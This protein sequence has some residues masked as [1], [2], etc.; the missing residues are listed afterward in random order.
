MTGV[1]IPRVGRLGASA[2]SGEVRFASMPVTIPRPS[3]RRIIRQFAELSD[4]PR[5][6]QILWFVLRFGW[7]VHHDNSLCRNPMARRHIGAPCAPH[8]IAHAQQSSHHRRWE[9]SPRPSPQ[10]LPGC[11][12]ESVFSLRRPTSCKFLQQFPRLCIAARC[13][14]RQHHQAV[15][16]GQKREATVVSFKEDP[17]SHG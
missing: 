14:H 5:R 12:P 3:G 9:N 16:P 7:K 2:R 10:T 8:L 4:S 11:P 17:P 1:T 13:L 15:E 6:K